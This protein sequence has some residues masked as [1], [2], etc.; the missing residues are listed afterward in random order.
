M[1]PSDFKSHGQAGQD[2]WV[3]EMLEHKQDGFY[4]DLGCSDAQKH[5]NTYALETYAGWSGLLVD[6]LD[7]CELRKGTFIKSD[8]ANPNGRLKLYY[9]TLPPLMDFL[10]LDC[11]D[12]TMGAFNALPWDD[13]R[14]RVATI[15]T[16]VYRKGPV[17]R[18]K[19]RAAMHGMGYTLVAGDVFVEW[20]EGTFVPYE[21]WYAHPDHVS[22]D[23]IKRFSCDGL[24]WKSILEL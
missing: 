18:D 15:E 10:S 19:I 5:S 8:A 21:D 12:A 6:T 7:G 20:P 4:V 23:Q 9:R 1:I 2:A 11:D 14:F 17:E 16:D 3:Y 24:F 22:P 13:I